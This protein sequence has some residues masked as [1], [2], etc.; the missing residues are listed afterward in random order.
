[1]PKF[2]KTNAR[3]TREYSPQT[4]TRR[5]SD[6][7]RLHEYLGYILMEGGND[8]MRRYPDMR[9]SRAE[10]ARAA[11]PVLE[12]LGLVILIDPLK[13]LPSWLGDRERKLVMRGGSKPIWMPTQSM[14]FYVWDR[15]VSEVRDGQIVW[16]NPV[17]KARGTM[18][19][20]VH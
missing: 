15:V 2:E 8:L 18:K 11:L 5:Y 20:A 3:N 1:M 19:S 7:V 16:L 9:V 17:E 12:R 6:G 4:D 14:P 10:F 13:P